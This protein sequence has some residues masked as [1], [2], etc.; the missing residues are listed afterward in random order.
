MIID[1]AVDW[2]WCD[3]SHVRYSVISYFLGLARR[4]GQELI[5]FMRSG[6][7]SI[8]LVGQWKR[9]KVYEKTSTMETDK[10]LQNNGYRQHMFD[11]SFELDPDGLLGES[12]PF[13]P[14]LT[15]PARDKP[16]FHRDS[17][18]PKRPV[19]SREGGE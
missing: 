14:F 19:T 3:P 9:G 12:Y 13:Y 6:N 15:Y 2:W 4:S 10:V 16:S 5:T 1:R 7:T 8:Q 11:S 18:I 17:C